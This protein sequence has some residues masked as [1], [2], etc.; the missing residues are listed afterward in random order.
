MVTSGYI[1]A[2]P[3]PDFSEDIKLQL[4]MLA[5][6]VLSEQKNPLDAVDEIDRILSKVL[7]MSASTS[8]GVKEFA[9]NLN[10]RV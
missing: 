2:L 6:D 10:S 1:N 8:R 7:K 4:S 9:R 5:M 3:V